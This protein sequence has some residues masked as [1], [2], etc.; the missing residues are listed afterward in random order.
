MST[1]RSAD[2]Q[3]DHGAQ[4]FTAHT[5]EFA[6]F[7]EPFIQNDLVAR[8]N[9]RLAMIG[10]GSPPSWSAPRYVAV[11]GMNAL[12][13]AMAEGVQV[14]R[15]Q[16]VARIAE[17]SGAWE[18]TDV[19]GQNCG[20]FD[21]VISTAPAE[22]TAV[23]MPQ[24]FSHTDRLTDSQMQ[25]CYTLMLGLPQAL[26]VGWDAAVVAQGPL[27]WIAQNQSKPGRSSATS[28][29]VQSRDD[30]V[31][32]HLEADQAW[33]EEALITA[34]EA[35]IDASVRQAD[36]VSL[37]RWRFAKVRTPAGE[38]CL[39]DAKNRL[40]ACGDWCEAGRVEAAYSSAVALCDMMKD[41]L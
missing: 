22:Q 21:W 23:L 39:F 26:D 6:E 32:E 30:W 13:K 19:E 29:V 5:S 40:A 24:C 8:W 17:R 14:H 20:I 41:N 36:Y 2:Y 28:L 35:V 16:R 15:A 27:V 37:H 7:L 9:P 31:T 38:R 11:P 10:A 1:R 3:F 34:S 33:V 18:L 4:Y 12:A 25:A